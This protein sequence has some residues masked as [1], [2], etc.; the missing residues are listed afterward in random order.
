MF[1]RR[2]KSVNSLAIL[3]LVVAMIA[4]LFLFTSLASASDAELNAVQQAIAETGAK[5]TAGET[6]ISR[7]PPEERRRRL[8]GKKPVE[9]ILE[10]ELPMVS[11]STL[12][13]LP[14][15]LNYNESGYVSTIKN[16]GNC[17]SCWA[18]GPT[19]ALESQILMKSGILTDEAEQILVSCCKNPDY[20][21]MDNCENGGYASDASNFIMN[22]GLPPESYYPYTA[23]DGN[24]ANAET[25]WQSHTYDVSTWWYVTNDSPSVGAL[26]SGLSSYG[27]LAVWMEVCTDFENYY[28]GGIYTHVSGTCPEGNGHFVEVI[29][30]DDS[31]ECLIVKNSWGTNWGETETG[32]VSTRGFFRIAYSEVTGAS[33]FGSYA[34]AYSPGNQPTTGNHFA[35]S[36]PSSA[37][38]G[39]KF[40]FTVEALDYNGNKL[41]TYTGTVGF[42]SSDPL[43]ALP[44]SSTLIK[45]MKTFT[46]TL[47]TT[48]NQTLT[49]TD[50]SFS[51]ITGTSSAI[52]VSG[53]LS[54]SGSVKTAKG[55]GVPGVLMT[56]SNGKTTTTNTSGSYTF[57]HLGS[58]A[59]TVVPSESGYVFSPSS[60]QVTLGKKSLS[61]INF[62]GTPE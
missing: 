57:P 40:S 62:K 47:N 1:E 43:A 59:Y 9:K 22:T 50:K 33:Q 29:G 30:Y 44:S 3:S 28:T 10:S 55:K 51:S 42:T 6:S 53:T 27:P 7:L 49:A 61:N 13:A 45:G 12:A 37:T 48:G 31:N 24:C 21:T 19:A 18:F 16:Q 34:I 8:G 56:L 54:I 23:T 58:G 2:K 52:S 20:P 14:S 11:A 32:S 5:W 17:G 26:K 39:K 38:T 25:G 60:S 36:A 41:T 4:G 46:A 35:V 15:Y